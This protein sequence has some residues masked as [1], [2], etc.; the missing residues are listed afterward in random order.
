M[1]ARETPTTLVLTQAAG[2]SGIR[3]RVKQIGSEAGS[4]LN[5][6]AVAKSDDAA[7]PLPLALTPAEAAHALECSRDFFDRH[8]G[9]ELRWV[10]RGPRF[11]SGRRL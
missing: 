1:T 4:A 9:P 11:E 5:G 10:R 3:V 7:S 2:R 8:I 6:E